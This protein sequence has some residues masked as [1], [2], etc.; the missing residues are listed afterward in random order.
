MGE[1]DRIM[2]IGGTLYFVVPLG[3]PSSYF[4]A[5]RVYGLDFILSVFSNYE[6][7]DFLFIQGLTELEPVR[8]PTQEYVETWPY[9]C[10]CFELKK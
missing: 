1:L 10:G 2:A 8:F 9:G 7:L 6:V 3:T 5:H 4:S